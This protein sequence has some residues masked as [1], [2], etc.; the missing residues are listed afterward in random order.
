MPVD[1]IMQKNFNATSEKEWVLKCTDLQKD[2]QKRDMI[3]AT[4][5]VC[6]VLAQLLIN[7]GYDTPKKAGSFLRMEQ[8]MLHDPFEMKD[9]DRAVE[10][11]KAAIDGGEKI[12]IYGDY[13]VDGVTSVS[14]LYL[15]LAE[16]GANVCYYIPNRTAEGYG[17]SKNAI[18]ALAGEGVTLIVTVDTG[19]TAN[20]EIE[21]AKTLGIDFV[22]T[23]H[24]ECQSD[25][26]LAA[27]VVNPHRPDCT[28]PFKELA[29]V[30]V[31]FK[32][33]S[34][35]EQKYS[36]KTK[37]DALTDICAT[38]ADLIAIGTIADVMPIKDENKLIVSYGLALIRENERVGLSALIDS[39]GH[40]NEGA[41][42]AAV[43]RKAP[44]ITSSYIGYTIA[45]KINAAGR[46][47][48]AEIAVELFL[49][50]DKAHAAIL[51]DRL[52]D[53]NKSRQD[54]ENRIIEEAYAQIPS[55]YDAKK[56][57][58]IVL[59]S[60]SW[61]HGVIGIVASRITER[62][63]L[64]SILISFDGCDSDMSD[65]GKGSGRSIKG[66]NLVDAL[67]HCEDT[68]V[69]FGGHELAAGMSVTREMLPVF[70]ERIN[71]YAREALKVSSLVHTLDADMELSPEDVNIA[72]AEQINLL[73]PF[74][75][76]NPTPVFILRDAQILEINAV[77]GGKHTRLTVRAGKAVFVAM[78]FSHSP[79]SL[80][81]SEGDTV[82]LLFNLDVNEW[83]GRR[84][85]QL[86]VKDI[87]TSKSERD[88]ARA[89]A[90][91]FDR[92]WAG[93]SYCASDNVLP[94][95]DDFAAVYN[96]V[97][98]SIRAGCDTLS[99]TH[100]Q[101]RLRNSGERGIGYT[102]LKFIIKIFQELNLLG[103][104][105]GEEGIYSFSLRFSN[106]KTDLEK[107]HLLKRLRLQQ[108]NG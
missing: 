85:V 87:H 56:Y 25:I 72:V 47:S 36:G 32:L 67:L 63:G 96:L 45:P 28:Y 5:G 17:V 16:K 86:L 48:S 30:G 51:A 58:V 94:D 60:D 57:P 40:K 62:F 12:A 77:G 66:L 70:R 52:F 69:K 3:C 34:A 73:E 55:D 27:A 88:E 81:F 84:T 39:I 59:D 24:H 7:R 104:S 31:V 89:G 90:E 80:E 93:G 44:K 68:L 41:T 102:K 106:T 75:T 46:M 105:E 54:E 29:G 107:S 76:E 71:E 98:Q 92:I 37:Y 33:I 42:V 23:D 19:I 18:E 91:S 13:D 100:M 50:N 101:R 53:A 2:K 95:R 35:Y 43:K 26:P 11:I 97:R 8:E 38:Y 74:G 6:D 1:Y 49:T 22:V 83:N 65:V 15:Y 20:E 78:Y 21:Y 10:R 9:M 108:K 103:I 61:H 14:A 99:I 64:P 79:T 82:D 4:L